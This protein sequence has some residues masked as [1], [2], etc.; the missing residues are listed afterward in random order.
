MSPHSQSISKSRVLRAPAHPNSEGPF[1]SLRVTCMSHLGYRHDFLSGLSA[2]ARDP[3][4]ISLLLTQQ[5]KDP[6]NAECRRSPV[7][8]PTRLLVLLRKSHLR[9]SCTQS[10]LNI[11]SLKNNFF[12]GLRNAKINKQNWALKS[13]S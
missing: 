1:T 7:Q 8:C 12:L 11:I 5:Q 4:S 10:N 3:L 6:L 9:L 13:D 2:C